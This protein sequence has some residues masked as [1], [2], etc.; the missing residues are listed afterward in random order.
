[1]A[2]KIIVT[3]DEA[4][5]CPKCGES[6]PLHQGITKQTIQKYEKEFEAASQEREQ[7]IREDVRKDEERRAKRTY[8]DR[9]LELS[10]QLQASQAA[11][12]KAEASIAKA[13]DAARAQAILELQAEKD[14][15]AA[16]LAG[17]NAAITEFRA[18]ELALRQQKQLLEQE[19][20]NLEL[21]VQRRIDQERQ[22]IQEQASKLEAERFHLREAEYKKKL[23]D[24]QERLEALTRKLEHGSEQL[25]G[26]VFELEI[27]QVLRTAFPHDTITPVRKGQ[28][29]ADVLQI[30]HTNTGQNCGTIIWELK[31]AEN[32]SDKWVQKLKDDQLEANAELAV[33]VS[34]CMP[35]GCQEP[36]SVQS[37]IWVAKAQV[38]RPIAQTLRLMLIEAYNIKLANT[39]RSE[40]VE[41]LYDYFCSPQFAQRVRAVVETFSAMKHDL[42]REKSAIM[43]LW[44]K[45]E[46]QLDRVS[47]SMSA[48]VGE[49]QA[50]ASESLPQLEAIEQLSLPG[51]EDV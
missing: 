14:E 22:V 10:E 37:G 7:E 4:I 19:K 29:G 31:R 32:W 16:D 20:E 45:R 35:D 49:L 48:M 28:R 26:E 17:K 5:L 12:V 40:K 44:K 8:L 11:L 42:D 51:T 25:Q 36:F 41:A 9:Q 21:Q 23:E 24:A 39:G 47:G 6:F 38:V 33:L 15:L 30:V 1:M 18:N 2:T 43:T 13:A 27:E 34:A 3:S 46:A 50:I